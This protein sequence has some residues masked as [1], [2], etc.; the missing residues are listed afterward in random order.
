VRETIWPRVLA[1]DRRQAGATLGGLMDKVIFTL[2]AV[3]VGCYLLR[4]GFTYI[5]KRHHIDMAS[6]RKLMRQDAVK[7]FRIAKRS[8]R[9]FWKMTRWSK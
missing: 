4:W 3:I 6:E 7:A 2:I 5:V 9:W 1:L 8:T